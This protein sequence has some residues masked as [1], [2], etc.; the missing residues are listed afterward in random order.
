MGWLGW[1]STQSR[2]ERARTLMQ[3]GRG[4]AAVAIWTKLAI[5]GVPRAQTNLGASL[6][7][8]SG[9]QQDRAA[10]RMWLQRG[11]EA[12][13]PLGQ[14]NL[15]TLLLPED[16]AAAAHWYRQAAEQ[17]DAVGQDQLS[18]MLL[19]G[20]G[21]PQALAEARVWAERAARQGDAN[22]AARLGTMCH[23]ATGGGRDPEQAAHWWRIAAMAGD[24]DAAAML[25]AAL[26]T[27]QGVAV[28]QVAAMAWLIVASRRHSALV[29]PF[30]SRVEQSLDPAELA[31]ARAMTAEWG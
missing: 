29:R 3:A 18:R 12:G 27:G 7:I 21:V 5:A 17:G 25:G 1:P 19:A 10:A 30:F 4:P 20:E 6:A 26:H 24:G 8:G 2:L 28:D 9:I 23:E 22:A 11:A 13:D 16:A 14:R 15:A 31:R